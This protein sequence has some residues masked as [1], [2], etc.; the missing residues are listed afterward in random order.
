MRSVTHS[1]ACGLCSFYSSL[2]LNGWNAMLRTPNTTSTALVRFVWLE[3]DLGVQSMC[4]LIITSVVVLLRSPAC[5][6]VSLHGRA[7]W[8][9]NPLKFGRLHG[10]GWLRE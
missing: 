8:R 1:H 9:Q 10:W 4:L 5:M 3:F 2:P 7:G 6:R